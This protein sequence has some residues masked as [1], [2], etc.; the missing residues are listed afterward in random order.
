MKKLLTSAL[1]ISRRDFLAT[2]LSRSFI[3]FILS[4]MLIIGFSGGV[5]FFTAS[6]LMDRSK[7][8]KVAVI[9][10]PA[11]AA[12]FAKRYAMLAKQYPQLTMDDTLTVAPAPDAATQAQS[13]LTRADQHIS[14]VLVGLPDAPHLI[15]PRSTIDDLKEGVRLTLD[16]MAQ[17]AALQTAGAKPET[18]PLVEVARDP[19]NNAI[20]GQRE[21]LGKF[22]TTLLFF[23]NMLLAGMM[24]SNLVEE[25]ANKIIE[26][27]VAALP[28]DAVF[29][30]KLIGM[31]GVALTIVLAYSALL[32]GAYVLLAN[33]LPPELVVGAPAVSWPLFILLGYAYFMM[34]YLV[35]GGIFLGIGAQANTPREV[36]TISLPA[37]FAQMGVF[38]LATV[39]VK[40]LLSSL[41]FVGAIFPLSTPLTMIDFAARDAVLWPHLLA[42]AWE[43]IWVVVI[44]RFAGQR[45]RSNVL[46]SGPAKPK[47]RL[48]AAQGA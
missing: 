7:A 17:E 1:V 9:A 29:L 46:K 2:V 3:L 41:W 19:A 47:K 40:T 22:G 23:L 33:H 8:P 21:G 39:A 44:V 11:T 14:A 10:P 26:I 27:L 6:S 4:P 42:L 38:L 48:P 25:K 24:L 32:G 16:T 20:A 5:G 45:F 34:N 18:V 35:V 37:T 13:L 30:G 36:Q 43:A 15:G 28:I 12:A 31:L